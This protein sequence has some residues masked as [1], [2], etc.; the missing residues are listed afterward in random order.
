MFMINLNSS[1][2]IT[3]TLS[4]RRSLISIVANDLPAPGCPPNKTPIGCSN[5]NNEEL[6]DN[7]PH[8]LG[9]LLLRSLSNHI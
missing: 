9:N 4:F 3:R 6:F 5:E 7:L 8:T 2:L 1:P